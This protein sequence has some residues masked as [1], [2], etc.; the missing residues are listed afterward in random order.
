MTGSRFRELLMASYLPAALLLKQDYDY[1]EG[2][3]RPM[4]N[5]I[6]VVCLLS[7]PAIW[8]LADF[9]VEW[10]YRTADNFIKRRAQKERVIGP[11]GK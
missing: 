6:I 2:E 3:T 11:E 5:A 4:I 1:C 8:T 10:L 7:I 9:C